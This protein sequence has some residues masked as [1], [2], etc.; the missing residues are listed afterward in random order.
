MDVDKIRKMNVL[1]NTLKEH[2]LAATR[3]DAVCLAGE[4]VGA[5]E[6]EDV[7]RVL[8][9]SD[10]RIEINN[11]PDQTKINENMDV[12]TMNEEKKGFSEEQIKNILQSF[13]DQFCAEIKNLNEK[14]QCQEE[15]YNKLQEK[16]NG[17]STQNAVGNQVVQEQVQEEKQT[18]V[19][20]PKQVE[21]QEQVQT[22]PV[23]TQET[24]TTCDTAKPPQSSGR[25][26]E[27]N[28]NDVSIDK[29]FYYGQK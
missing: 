7:T 1:T 16:F 13:T 29:F 28:S 6:D 5:S 3:E 19:E 17:L 21:P 15:M 27:Y 2:G 18:I 11:N 8:N 23:Q 25:C 20:Q 22:Q 4:M 10:Q 14:I 26:G 24:K 9:E 12:N